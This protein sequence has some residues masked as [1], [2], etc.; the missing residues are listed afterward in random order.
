MSLKARI[1]RNAEA[2]GENVVK[3][4]CWKNSPGVPKAQTEIRDR[5]S[6]RLHRA[7]ICDLSDSRFHSA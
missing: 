6:R 3:S 1:S 2:A 5:A 7:D 4:K